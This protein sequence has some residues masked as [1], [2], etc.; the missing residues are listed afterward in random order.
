MCVCVCARAIYL[1]RAA[2]EWD[3]SGFKNSLADSFPFASI[4]LTDSA[5]GREAASRTLN[6]RRTTVLLHR[7]APVLNFNIVQEAVLIRFSFGFSLNHL[8][9]S[10]DIPSHVSFQASLF[11]NTLIGEPRGLSSFRPWFLAVGRPYL[12]LS[13]RRSNG[14]TGP[15][16]GCPRDPNFSPLSASFSVAPLSFL[17]FSSSASIPISL[18]HSLYFAKLTRWDTHTRESPCIRT[19]TYTTHAHRR[20]GSCPSDRCCLGS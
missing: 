9:Q 3:D 15:V 11:R 6:H 4:R 8:R 14:E 17:S 13:L 12:P 19:H 7:P 5:D 16:D 1:V 10:I 18:C 20:H 2:F